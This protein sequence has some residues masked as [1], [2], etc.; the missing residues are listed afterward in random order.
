[1]SS[2]YIMTLRVPAF[3]SLDKMIRFQSETLTI[4]EGD[5]FKGAERISFKSSTTDA[6]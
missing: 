4:D 2:K 3:F 6:I 1:M 5:C